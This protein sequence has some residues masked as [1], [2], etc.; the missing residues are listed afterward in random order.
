M[1]QVT[2]KENLSLLESDFLKT[3]MY[4]DIFSYPLTLKEIFACSTVKEAS[5]PQYYELADSLAEK[6]WIY[7]HDRFYGFS[8]DPEDVN[9]RKK[10][11]LLARKMLQRAYWI[12][13]FIASFPFVRGVFLSG[14]ITKNFMTKES[15]IDF[16]IVT[17]PGRLW[18]ARTMLVMFKKVFLLNSHKYFCVNYFVDLNHL[19]IEE[20]NRFTA[21][22]LVYL[23]P[24]YGAGEYLEFCKANPWARTIFPHFPLRDIQQIP[25]HRKWGI[26]WLLEWVFSGKLGEKLDQKFMRTTVNHWRGKFDHLTEIDWDLA[27]KSRKYVS[28]HHPQNFQLKVLTAHQEKMTQFEE[29][30]GVILS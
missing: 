23:I 1:S 5:L 24:T 17:K 29:K 9:R 18:I 12:S 3:L 15:D 14:S 16:F 2:T 21:T 6:G 25:Q 26:K 22:E 10:G 8:P 11:N 13:R 30:Y 19:E 28:K 7:Q 4:F 20:K 27:M